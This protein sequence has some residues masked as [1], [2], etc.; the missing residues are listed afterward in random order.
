MRTK[1]IALFGLLTAAAMLL[2]WL[3][4]LLPPFLAA[5]GIKLGVANIAVVFALY[6]LGP[7][8]AAAVSFVRVA[9]M[10]LLFG[11]AF[12]LLYSAAGAVLALGV[13]LLLRRTD[14]FSPT[15]VSIAGGVAHN[16][17][18][19]A[20]AAAVAETPALLLYLPVLLAAGTVAGIVIGLLAGI[21]IRRIPERF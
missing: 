4:S 13:M 12:A 8:G 18:Q 19:I 16:V 7:K 20:V 3:E 21:L 17:G 2:S 9:L 6:R 14:R 11:N 10:N 1:Q 5:P 15:G